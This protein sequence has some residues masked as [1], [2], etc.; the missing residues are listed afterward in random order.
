MLMGLI[1][2]KIRGIG[3]YGETAA[4]CPL[5]RDF[6]NGEYFYP[7]AARVSFLRRP[8]SNIGVNSHLIFLLGLSA[9]RFEYERRNDSDKS[10]E[11]E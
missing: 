4:F 7:F 9:D 8:A 11:T 6:I 2:A 5:A 10:Y 1:K 3:S